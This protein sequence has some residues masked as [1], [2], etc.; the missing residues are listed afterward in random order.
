V[1][2]QHHPRRRR[3]RLFK[4]VGA[5]DIIRAEGAFGFVVCG[6]KVGAN[7]R[8]WNAELYCGDA[9]STPAQP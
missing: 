1:G 6:S 5:F 8:E 2:A 9:G 4:A 3:V 7:G